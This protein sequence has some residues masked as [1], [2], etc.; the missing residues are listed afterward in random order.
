MVKRLAVVA[1]TLVAVAAG[2]GCVLPVAQAN[3]GNVGV[4]SNPADDIPSRDGCERT[5]STVRLTPADATRY[6]IAG[7]LCGPRSPGNQEVEFL[8]H[9]FS[10][11]HLY[12]MG[13]GVDRLD[14]VR[15]ASQQGRTTFVIDQLG[16]GESDHPDPQQTT[17]EN[18]AYTVHQLV[19]QLRAGQIGS[20]HTRFQRVIGVGH[21]MGAGTWIVESGTYRDVNAVILAD[22]LHT[23]D[24]GDVAL[25]SENT[26]VANTL[27][28]FAN[29]PDGYLTLTQR[30]LFYDVDL[31]SPDVLKL[32]GE[33]GMD[34]GTTGQYGTLA[35]S[36]D[37][38][39]SNAI[40]APVL[41]VSG[42][43]DA[44]F[45]NESTGLSCATAGAVLDREAPVF[46]SAACLDAFVF[47]SGH[48]T[49][50]HETAPQLFDYAGKWV[51]AVDHGNP[52][53]GSRSCVGA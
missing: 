53:A 24:P 23:M 15:A 40:T 41:I 20:E 17:F 36:S 18:L 38:K 3:T 8:V 5:T 11:N 37:P 49:N 34:T 46:S 51:D 26:L 6:R 1:A 48:D 4:H 45:C 27:S 25:L 43:Q 31:V 12:W 7:W 10:Y 29:L 13:L 47:D 50:L 39:F 44:L 19:G 30:S 14:Y 9:G 2:L 32:D 42:R 35:D 22:D 28:Q 21:S 52:P 33:I 16:V